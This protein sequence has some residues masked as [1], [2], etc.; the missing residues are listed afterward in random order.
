MEKQ[1]I[2]INI[3]NLVENLFV[4]NGDSEEAMRVVKKVLMKIV[5]DASEEITKQDKQS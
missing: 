2:V 5:K 4:I 1:Q 3:H